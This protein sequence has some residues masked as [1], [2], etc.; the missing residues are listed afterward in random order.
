M[1]S[2][3]MGQR[4]ASEQVKNL[5]DVD[6]SPELVSKINDHAGGAARQ[7]RPL[8]AVYPFVFLDAIHFKAKENHQYQTTAEGPLTE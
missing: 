2:P 4:G 7:N 3:G 1:H 6:I 8:E 5:Y